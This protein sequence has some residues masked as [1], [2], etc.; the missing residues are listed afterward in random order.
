MDLSNLK[1]TKQNSLGNWPLVKGSAFYITLV[2]KINMQ[3]QVW[4]KRNT[5]WF[6]NKIIYHKGIQS[7]NDRWRIFCLYPIVIYFS[8]NLY[9]QLYNTGVGFCADY[10]PG[11]ATAEGS[12]ELSPCSDSPTQVILWVCRHCVRPREPCRRQAPQHVR[13]WVDTSGNTGMFKISM[14]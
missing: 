3:D 5:A 11:R 14:C 6:M 13:G 7:Q 4:K 10:R 12:I 2:C 9:L 8:I 1:K